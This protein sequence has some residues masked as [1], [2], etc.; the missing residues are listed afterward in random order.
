MTDIC[1]G[2]GSGLAHLASARPNL[3]TDSLSHVQEPA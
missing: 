3:K 2:V 1:I